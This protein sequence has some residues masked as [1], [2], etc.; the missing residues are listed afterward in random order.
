MLQPH[1]STVQ[2]YSYRRPGLLLQMAFCRPCQVMRSHNG[3]YGAP[4]A[5][6]WRHGVY[7]ISYN[8]YLFS[9]LDK[10]LRC[11]VTSSWLVS[12]NR[13][14]QIS[15]T[16]TMLVVSIRFAAIANCRMVNGGSMGLQLA[17]P[18]VHLYPCHGRGCFCQLLNE[19]LGCLDPPHPLYTTLVILQKVCSKTS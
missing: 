18:N 19:Q 1:S 7:I 6:I 16:L 15:R 10:F 3:A 9:I 2:Q 11:L 12:N 8:M 14:Q 5:S 13:C 4:W 17:A